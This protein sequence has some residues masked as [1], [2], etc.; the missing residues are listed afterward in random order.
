MYQNQSKQ[1]SPINK[2]KHYQISV[3]YI[4]V[5]IISLLLQHANCKTVLNSIKIVKSHIKYTIYP[6]FVCAVYFQALNILI[7]T[8]CS[9]MLM[10]NSIEITITT[11][12]FLKRYCL[13][14]I[15]VSHYI[16]YILFTQYL[17]CVF[18]C[19]FYQIILLYACQNAKAILCTL[20]Q[21]YYLYDAKS[22]CL[23]RAFH[24]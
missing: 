17:C 23:C 18:L 20:C 21:E 12:V 15:C 9:N 3:C 24:L 7:L 13:P 1:F 8:Y 6:K 14:S 10:T 5:C 22:C 11:L 19:R 4:F 16:K 2:K